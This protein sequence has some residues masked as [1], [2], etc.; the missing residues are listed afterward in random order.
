[1]LE[2]S[3]ELSSKTATL[4]LLIEID[5]KEKDQADDLRRACEQAVLALDKVLSAT[6]MLTAHQAGPGINSKADDRGTPV[7]AGQQMETGPHKPAN[8]VIAVAS[9]KGGVGKSTTSINLASASP[10]LANGWAFLMPIFTVHL[11]HA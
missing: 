9:G 4:V 3:L 8:H 6:A 2:T 7:G 11:F 5:P 1:M 10:R